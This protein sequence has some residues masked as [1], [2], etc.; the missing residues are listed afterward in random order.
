MM[1]SVDQWLSQLHPSP[2]A[3]GDLIEKLRRYRGRPS[4]FP[5][6]MNM[7]RFARDKLRAD[8]RELDIIPGLWDEYFNYSNEVLAGMGVPRMISS[9][10]RKA[11]EQQQQ[12]WRDGIDPEPDE[13]KPEQADLFA[14]K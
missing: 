11:V 3:R 14:T 10:R 4:R 1:A 9:F 5:N 6:R 13:T 7:Y 8:R 12:R 2:D